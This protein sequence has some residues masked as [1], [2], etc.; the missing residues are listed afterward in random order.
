MP[1]GVSK[2][3]G[4][5]SRANDARVERQVGALQR[6]GYGKVPAIKIA[7]A[8][9]RRRAHG[10]LDAAVKHHEKALRRRP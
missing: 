6:K 3:L 9:M 1:Y 8:G 4:G 2:T 5:D 10:P 7:K